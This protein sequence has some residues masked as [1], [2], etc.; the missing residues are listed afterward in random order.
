MQMI[1]LFLGGKH[2]AATRD[3]SKSGLERSDSDA[4]VAID[5]L[6]LCGYKTQACSA[7]V[8]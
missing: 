8:A 5:Q 2:F 1:D 4:S 7:Q 3:E 6:A